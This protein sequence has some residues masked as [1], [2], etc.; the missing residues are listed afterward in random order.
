MTVLGVNLGWVLH[1]RK[2]RVLPLFEFER[3]LIA[4]ICM[5]AT[6][7]LL[8]KIFFGVLLYWINSYCRYFDMA[9][10]EVLWRL[11]I[12]ESHFGIPRKS[13]DCNSPPTD[14]SIAIWRSWQ[15]GELPYLWL[16]L[17]TYLEPSFYISGNF[18][19][20]A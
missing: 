9:E 8:K 18:Q 15:R 4:D 10:S 19:G 16:K 1:D 13:F 20:L 17:L 6:F 5:N 2:H 11:L 7:L 3:I 14:L 12:D